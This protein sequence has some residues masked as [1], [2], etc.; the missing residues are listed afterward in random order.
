MGGSTAYHRKVASLSRHKAVNN[1]L[2]LNKELEHLII[3]RHTQTLP[4]SLARLQHRLPQ[5]RLVRRR[6]TN[7]PCTSSSHMLDT[8]GTLLPTTSTIRNTCSSLRHNSMA[9]ICHSSSSSSSTGISNSS[10]SRMV[11]NDFAR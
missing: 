5:T 7:R 10:S 11:L 2:M 6:Q 3:R 8:P 1:T 4:L 9:S